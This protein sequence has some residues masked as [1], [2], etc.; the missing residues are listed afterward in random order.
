MIH[1]KE[2]NKVKFKSLFILTL[3]MTNVANAEEMERSTITS[4]AYQAGTAREIQTIRQN[5]QDSWAEFEQNVKTIYQDGQGRRD[6]LVIAKQ[7]YSQPEN[8]STDTIYNDIFSA[9]SERSK[10]AN[11]E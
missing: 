11:V 1:I 5:E 10:Q 7:V 9:C 2:G 4:C 8:T 3:L 6:L